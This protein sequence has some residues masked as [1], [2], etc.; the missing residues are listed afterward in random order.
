MAQSRTWARC[1]STILKRSWRSI[2]ACR[3]KSASMAK[4]AAKAR[5]RTRRRGLFLRPLCLSRTSHRQH[6]QRQAGRNGIFAPAGE[7]WLCQERD[8]AAVL[9]AM[10]LSD[11]LLGRVPEEPHHPHAGRRAG[12]EL[13]LSRFQKIFCPRAFRK[14]SASP[15]SCAKIPCRRDI[16]PHGDFE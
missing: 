10:R 9:P 8:L 11:G 3:R 15:P 14:S 5:H 13:S 12:A 1:W 4:F 2:W 16:Q 6:P 7:V